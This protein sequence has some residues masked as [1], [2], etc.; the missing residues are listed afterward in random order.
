M[1]ASRNIIIYVPK[2]F[3]EEELKNSIITYLSTPDK[4]KNQI[5]NNKEI[6]LNIIGD[7]IGWNNEGIIGDYILEIIDEMLGFRE[8]LTLDM[9][10]Y[11][12]NKYWNKIITFIHLANDKNISK[13]KL[14]ESLY[15]DI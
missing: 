3:N 12:V 2:E 14:L 9:S 6:V 11:Y 1:N 7:Y 15:V 4:V 8:T 5:L 10:V 13:E